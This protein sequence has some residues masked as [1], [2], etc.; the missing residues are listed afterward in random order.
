MIN[1][2]SLQ[3]SEEIS[4][5]LP[6]GHFAVDVTYF[7]GGVWIL[8]TS[9]T[10]AAALVEYSGEDFT[11]LRK[12]D[13]D[14]ANTNAVSI[15][16]LLTIPFPD[17]SFES[18]R[19]ELLG[20]LVHPIRYS[21]YDPY[22][23]RV[24]PDA[25]DRAD[26]TISV[27]ELDVNFFYIGESDTHTGAY[28]GERDS[29]FHA[30]GNTLFE[31][32]VKGQNSIERK[33][34]Y[35]RPLSLANDTGIEVPVTEV[36]SLCYFNGT[37][38]LYVLFGG[39]VNNLLKVNWDGARVINI[40]DAPSG[41]ERLTASQSQINIPWLSLLSD[42][43]SV[44]RGE[45]SELPMRIDTNT[46]ED[47]DERTGY[48]RVQ[49]L[50]NNAYELV[51]VKLTVGALGFD[52]SYVAWYQS[53]FARDPQASGMNADSDN[54]GISNALEYVIGTNPAVNDPNP[55]EVGVPKVI[56]DPDDGNIYMKFNR[57][58]GLPDGAV[59]IQGKANLT[60]DWQNLVEGTDYEIIKKETVN[61]IDRL[62]ISTPF[63]NSAFFRLLIS[64]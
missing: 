53:F 44:N 42:T 64:L 54:D 13:L 48:I 52:P 14:I 45:T 10:G 34:G 20:L 30:Q 29:I 46:L 55:E 59:E 47:G 24:R 37:S 21:S 43:G 28:G 18:G 2:Y 8:T 62:T 6:D 16:G 40:Y 50:E 23:Y 39:S 11:F 36:L 31:W 17:T 56:E 12:I 9:D 63:T 26:L 15:E 5:N 1:Q 38:S 35:L 7:Q 4:L 57:R 33:G 60:D 49:S 27:D 19:T 3:A 22:V 58:A 51:T 61:G 25:V 32:E 41:L